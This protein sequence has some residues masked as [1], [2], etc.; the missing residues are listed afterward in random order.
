LRAC[1]WKLLRAERRPI[2]ILLDV[3]L[4]GSF[5]PAGPTDQPPELR[6]ELAQ[7]AE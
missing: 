7:L 1:L 4:A 6:R 5:R 2:L 3:A